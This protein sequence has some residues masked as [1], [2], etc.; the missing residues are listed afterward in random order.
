MFC[1]YCGN[2][3]NNTANYCPKCG[4][5]VDNKTA[6]QNNSLDEDILYGLHIMAKLSKYEMISFWI[7]VGIICLQSLLCLIILFFGNDAMA[8]PLILCIAWNIYS[9]Y[10]TFRYA[11]SLMNYPTGVFYHYM[12]SLASIILICIVNL[13]TG[14]VFGIVAAVYELIVRHYAIEHKDAL[15]CA[16]AYIEVYIP[17]RKKL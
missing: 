15:L 1:V 11:K 7:W 12:T 5:P 17:K 14:A 9:N 16:E 8:I 4:K 3:L 6:T 10:T 13:C 2:A